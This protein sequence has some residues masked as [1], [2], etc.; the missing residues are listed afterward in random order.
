MAINGLIYTQKSF[1]ILVK[2]TRIRLYFPFFDWFW[3]KRNSVWFKIN[4]KTVYKIWFWLFLQKS[5]EYF[6]V[7]IVYLFFNFRHASRKVNIH[8]YIHLRIIYMYIYTCCIHIHVV[9]IY[10]YIYT[11]YIHVYVCIHIIYICVVCIFISWICRHVWRSNLISREC[12]LR[13]LR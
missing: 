11:Y 5:G 3:I 12:H 1:L 6:S 10:E 7:C 9:Y 13:C 8:I 4:R 2:A